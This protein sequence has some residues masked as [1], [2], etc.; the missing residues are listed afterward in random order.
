MKVDLVS[1]HTPVAAAERLKTAVGGPIY[2]DTPKRVTG[3]GTEQR[4]RLWIHRPH[5]RNDLRT[6]LKARMEPYRGGT[7][8]RGR[9][10]TP[11][12]GI[13]FLVFWFG[14]VLLFFAGG[15]AGWIATGSLASPMFLVIPG[16]MLLFGAGFIYVATMHSREDRAMILDFLRETIATREYRG[17]DL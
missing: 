10:G 5:F 15:V 11:R 12:S 6:A 7:R 14:F 9:V 3:N 2:R 4:M 17:G 1:P 8:I 13:A 16:L